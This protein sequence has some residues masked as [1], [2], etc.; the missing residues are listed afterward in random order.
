MLDVEQ[1]RPAFE[2]AM[3]A[4]GFRTERLADG[5]YAGMTSYRWEGWI[6]GKEEGAPPCES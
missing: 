3:K 4:R 5:S 1:Q 2:A 6:A